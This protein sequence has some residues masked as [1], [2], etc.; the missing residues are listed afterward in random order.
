MLSKYDES[1]SRVRGLAKEISEYGLIR[2]PKKNSAAKFIKKL[3]KK[4]NVH[5]LDIM[6]AY[7]C[8]EVEKMYEIEFLNLLPSNIF[9]RMKIMDAIMWPQMGYCQERFQ[10]EF[11]TY[12]DDQARAEIARLQKSIR[13]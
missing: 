11:P 10:K 1:D 2:G 12:R 3:A 6:F 7:W 8:V 9:K 5:E 13:K 4:H